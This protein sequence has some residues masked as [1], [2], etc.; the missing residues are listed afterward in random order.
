KPVIAFLA[1]STN[2]VLRLLGMKT[3][4][5]EE[6]LTEEELRMMIELGKEKGAIDEDETEWIQ[7]VFDFRD[8]SI[9]SSMT[10]EAD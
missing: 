6:N 7:N 2:L 5:E 1:F 10:R 4:A 8:T 3:E 9:L